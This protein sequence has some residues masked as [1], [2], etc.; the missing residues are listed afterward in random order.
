MTFFD[1]AGNKMELKKNITTI[2]KK[3]ATIIREE[4]LQEGIIDEGGSIDTTWE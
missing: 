1:S 2:K 4:R 3:P